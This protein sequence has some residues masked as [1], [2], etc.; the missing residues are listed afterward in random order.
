MAT[1]AALQRRWLTCLAAFVHH[2]TWSYDCTVTGGC[3]PNQV[4]SS[5][6]PLHLPL[7][8]LTDGACLSAGAAFS[9]AVKDLHLGEWPP[10]TTYR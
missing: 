1:V 3:S 7:V 6:A 2:A 10:T 4:D 5:I 9:A 8:V